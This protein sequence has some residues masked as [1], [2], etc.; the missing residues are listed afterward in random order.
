MMYKPQTQK[1]MENNTTIRRLGDFICEVN[2]RNSNG[3]ISLSQGICNLKYFQN[4]RQVSATPEL[5]KIVRTGQFAYN[6]ATTRNGDKIS[7]ALREGPD[8]TVSSAYCVFYITDENVI[9]PHWLWL[10]F[11]RPDF[12]RYAI[13][14]SHGSAHEFFEFETMCNVKLSVPPIEEQRAIVARHR[15]IKHKI[16]VNHRLIA[17]LEETARTIYRHTFIDNIDPENLPQGWR[18]GTI[19][20]I[21]DISSGK[22]IIDKVDEINEI[23]KYPV[24]G[25][26]GIIG[27]S[28]GYNQAKPFIT[29]GRVGT[30]GVVNRYFEYAWTAD[31]VLVAKSDYYEFAVQTLKHVNYDELI[32]G[33]VQNLITQTGL[34]AVMIPIPPKSI[35]SEFENKVS[36]IAYLI[37]AHIKENEHLIKLIPYCI[38]NNNS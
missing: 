7:I 26:S 29:T 11:K 15:A 23:Y 36:K 12:D 28:K 22:S 9:D 20:D 27:Y 6:R 3:F 31:N 8:C 24:A 34:S 35:I 18:I 19:G 5:D 25:A 38:N 30:I 16:D 1:P 17:A 10:W 14:K 4:P 2:E 13:F 37:R 21:I 33:G 32:G